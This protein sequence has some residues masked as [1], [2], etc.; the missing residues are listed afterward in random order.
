MSE[1]SEIETLFAKSIPE[2]NSGCW[3]WF[4]AM[5]KKGY[6]QIRR[7]RTRPAT[8]VALE[9]DGRAVPKGW[10]ACH[11]CDNPSCVNPQHLFVGTALDNARDAMRKGRNSTPPVAKPGQGMRLTCKYGHE[12]AGD[13][14]YL[15]S[16]GARHCRACRARIGRAAKAAFVAR[17]LTTRG[18]DRIGSTKLNAESVRRIRVDTRP[19]GMIA[20]E[21]GVTAANIRMVKRGI[22]WGHV[23]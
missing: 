11:H 7:G 2:P 23:R 15:A 12:K 3:L 17:G 1:R 13:N 6:G 19:A 16:N 14:L 4:G 18:T 20:A 21:F 5:D 10:Q 22:T 9:M 8:H